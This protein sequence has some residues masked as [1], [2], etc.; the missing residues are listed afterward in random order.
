[1]AK[2]L[3]RS[4]VNS[5]IGGVCGGLAEY[6]DIDPTIVR[7]IAILLAFADGVGVIGYIVAWIIVPRR[8]LE[9]EGEVVPQEVTK[10]PNP[11]WFRFLPGII[12]IVI[13]GLLVFNNV[14]WWFHFWDFFW[15]A[16]LIGIG[17]LLIFG[18]RGKKDASP[19][20]AQASQEVK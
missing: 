7:I 10:G 19:G 11:E 16:V 15:P 14:Y 12:L 4:R 3:Y 8:P 13:G 6:F 18:R 20:S 2:R 1:M 5:K 17:L 9:A